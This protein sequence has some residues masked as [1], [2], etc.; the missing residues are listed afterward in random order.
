M[1]I[2]PNK[3]SDDAFAANVE[4]IRRG[5]DEKTQATKR[6]LR[7]WVDANQHW[8]NYGTINRALL[9]LGIER[10]LELFDEQSASDLVQGVLRK[11]LQ[12]RL[13]RLQ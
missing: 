8:G 3:E 2:P 10:Q 12:R 6:E 9:E 1:S 5:H 7:Q 13:G 4:T 11:V